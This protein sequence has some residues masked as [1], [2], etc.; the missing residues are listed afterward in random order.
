MNTYE[1]L[2][3]AI[4]KHSGMDEEQIKE[5]GEHGADTGWP[6][7]S[8]TVDLIKFYEEN[9]DDIYELLR[10]TADDLGHKNIEELV[11]SFNRSDM[12]DTPQGRKTL[13][14]WFTLEEVGRWLA[15]SEQKEVKQ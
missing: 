15:D 12:L 3:K 11:S 9:E 10:D 5:A 1:K 7:F 2:L 8:Y 13:L 14:A 6:G 4:K